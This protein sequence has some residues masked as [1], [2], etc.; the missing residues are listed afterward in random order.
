MA[1]TTERQLQ[2]T[3]NVEPTPR[4]EPST[5]AT[6]QRAT[7]NAPPSAFLR[8]HLDEFAR[9]K[10]DFLIRCAA[11]YGDVVPI[12][13][14]PKRFW[15]V[16]DPAIVGE[17]LVTRASSFKKNIAMRRLQALFGEGLLISDGPEHE[18]R[19]Q[20]L[21]PALSSAAVV[22]YAA[23]VGVVSNRIFE[24]WNEG[25]RIDL[26]AEFSRL[27]LSVLAQT[28]FGVDI[29][30]RATVILDAFNQFVAF[31]DRRFLQLVP[32]PLFLPSAENRKAGA[33]LAIL[34][35]EARHIVTARRY[36][37]STGEG[38]LLQLMATDHGSG[39]PKR[40]AADVK[41]LLW[42]GSETS[43]NTLTYICHLLARHPRVREALRRE[44]DQVVGHRAVE[45]ADVPHLPFTR[46]VIRESLRLFPPGWLISREAAENVTLAGRLPLRRG[47][48]IGTSAYIIQRDPRWFDEPLAFRPE[49]FALDAPRPRP[50]TYFP[51]GAGARGCTGQAFA[52]LELALVL[53]T[54]IRRF[55]LEI[56]AHGEPELWPQLTLRSRHPIH[57]VVRS[58]SASRRGLTRPDG[59]P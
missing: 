50:N 43:A 42:V 18:R 38:L 59:L 53:P 5:T 40:L 41:I 21:R 8:G 51:F 47:E 22:H 11:E 1:F 3:S 20:L 55:E 28:L 7:R 49:R 57:A 15:F 52:E 35:E 25:R 10:L 23:S 2:H 16:S 29:L 4:A 39:N 9:D 30:D 37:P 13:F 26:F 48:M 12:R 14:G 27:T 19:M 33:A 58:A 36:D 17:F 6:P 45:A 31:M 34:D 56:D 24:A 54:V 44:V 46:Q 32:P